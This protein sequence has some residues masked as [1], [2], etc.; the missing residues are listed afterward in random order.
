MRMEKHITLQE[1]R[2]KQRYFIIKPIYANILL[3]GFMSVTQTGR[4]KPLWISLR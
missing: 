4:T 3:F 2:K 1:Q